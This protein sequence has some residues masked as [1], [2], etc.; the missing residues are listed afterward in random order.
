MSLGCGLLRGATAT[1][2]QGHWWRHPAL[3]CRCCCPALD[4][5][6]LLWTADIALA[7]CWKDVGERSKL[8]LAPSTAACFWQPQQLPYL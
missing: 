2:H 7:R 8:F 3:D 1:A 6:T 5:A 4:S